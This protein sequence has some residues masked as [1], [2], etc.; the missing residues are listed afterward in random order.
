MIVSRTSIIRLVMS[1]KVHISDPN[2]SQLPILTQ[3]EIEKS[4]TVNLGYS[5]KFFDLTLIRSE[6]ILDNGVIKSSGIEISYFF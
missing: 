3:K 6:S 4:N 5:F 2:V 1:T